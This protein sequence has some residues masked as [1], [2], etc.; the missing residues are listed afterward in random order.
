M[1]RSP[2]KT[3]S[4]ADGTSDSDL[5][6]LAK[7]ADG[8][9]ARDLRDANHADQVT[10]LRAQGDAEGIAYL[11]VA[12]LKPDEDQKE[13]FSALRVDDVVYK[14]NFT[15]ELGHNLGCNHN[16]PK[17]GLYRFSRGY[18][19]NLSDGK[20]YGTIMSYCGANR[21]ILY[22]SNPGVK[23]PDPGSGKPTGEPELKPDG[24]Q[25]PDAADC[26][27]TIRDSKLQ[28]ANYRQSCS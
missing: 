19:F 3:L 26:A 12:P 5:D 18:C 20:T 15:H 23:Y 6:R 28:V 1:S 7:G 13:A 9:E 17:K 11:L 14:Y 2:S 8:K 10:L 22:Y 24:S 25:N 21:R 16:A 4:D 27:R